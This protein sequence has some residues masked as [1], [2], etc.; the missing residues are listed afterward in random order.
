MI[1][2]NDPSY[3]HWEFLGHAFIS[4]RGPNF[5]SLYLRLPFA[6]EVLTGWETLGFSSIAYEGRGLQVFVSRIGPPPALKHTSRTLWTS[7][8][9]PRNG[10]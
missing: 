7:D 9:A 1:L 5:W 3:R 4:C 6:L 2:C 8:R 10:A